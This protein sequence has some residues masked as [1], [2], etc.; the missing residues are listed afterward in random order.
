MP[1]KS[2]VPCADGGEAEREAAIKKVVLEFPALK[3]DVEILQRQLPEIRARIPECST[4]IEL[5]KKY[6][7]L[8]TQEGGEDGPFGFCHTCSRFAHLIS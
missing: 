1:L 7:W 2:R 5:E 4:R 8:S 6:Q 3:S